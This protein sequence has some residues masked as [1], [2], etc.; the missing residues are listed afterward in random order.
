MGRQWL[1]RRKPYRA[2]MAIQS[3]VTERMP[4]TIPG[5]TLVRGNRKPLALVRVVVRRK[6]AVHSLESFPF[7]K[8]KTT[9]NPPM[10]ATTLRLVWRATKA[11]RLI[12]RIKVFP[13]VSVVGSFQS[14]HGLLCIN[15]ATL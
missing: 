11:D 10:M 12:P 8:A 14:D 13:F 3:S 15:I 6:T 2:T 4:R 5:V 9:K 1:R 7:N